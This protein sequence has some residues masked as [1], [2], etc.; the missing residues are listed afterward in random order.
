[1]QGKTRK[2][3]K[4]TRLNTQACLLACSPVV[5]TRQRSA[6]SW[7]RLAPVALLQAASTIG[8]ESTTTLHSSIAQADCAQ[9]HS[10]HGCHVYSSTRDLSH[11]CCHK[12][13]RLQLYCADCAEQEICKIL[14][15]NHKHI[16]LQQVLARFW[17]VAILTCHSESSMASK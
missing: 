5:S 8:A 2:W 10:R 13:C 3:L 16:V 15:M 7:L 11:A 12:C 4:H 17:A 14:I 1:M 9:C 6:C